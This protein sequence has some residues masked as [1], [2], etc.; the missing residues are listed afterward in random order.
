MALARECTCPAS[1]AGPSA[2]QVPKLRNPPKACRV[3]SPRPERAVEFPA[4]WG[5][6]FGPAGPDVIGGDPGLQRPRHPAVAFGQHAVAEQPQHR[7]APAGQELKR[8]DLACLPGAAIGQAG[9]E[10]RLVADGEDL[11]AVLFLQQPGP[12]RATGQMACRGLDLTGGQPLMP[13]RTSPPVSMPHHLTIVVLL[14]RA[15]PGAVADGGGVAD[16]E[17]A[18]ELRGPGEGRTDTVHQVKGEEADAVLVL[19][20]DDDRTA[21]LLSH[22]TEGGVPRPETRPGQNADDTAEA[23]RVLYVAATRAK[24]LVALALPGRHIPLVAQHLLGLGVTIETS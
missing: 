10:D 21:R 23:L 17:K 2:S 16:P 11:V 3:G 15:G 1:V 7:Q 19:P 22:W 18:D 5:V 12:G 13:H 6:Q 20:P 8:G 24:R 9:L 14:K 4:P